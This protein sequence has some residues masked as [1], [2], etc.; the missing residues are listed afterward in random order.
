MMI[1]SLNHITIGVN[2]LGKSF[3]FY[4]QIL[5]MKPIA[6]WNKGAYLMSG[7]TWV[8]LALEERLVKNKSNDQSHIAF[9]VDEKDFERLASR[10]NESCFGT[11]RENM[12]ETENSD[13]RI[14][15]ACCM[16]TTGLDGYPNSRIVSLKEVRDG[17]FI[18]AV[19][20]DSRKGTE[21]Q[22]NRIHKRTLYIANKLEWYRKYLQP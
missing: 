10:I 19:P 8:C 4:T 14:P 20:F 5:G 6:I 22:I 17:R 3:G 21:I 16:A 15:S 11:W 1:G 13:V 12:E 7:S 2:G 9:S 18:I